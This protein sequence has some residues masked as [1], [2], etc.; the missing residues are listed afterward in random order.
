M[1]TFQIGIAV[2]V[3]LDL[4]VT[5]PVFGQAGSQRLGQAILEPILDSDLLVGQRIGHS[6]RVTG[7]HLRGQPGGQ[8][9][10]N[11]QSRQP[12]VTIPQSNPQAPAVQQFKPVGSSRPCH[13]LEHRSF[14]Q[15]HPEV[16]QQRRPLLVSSPLGL[17]LVEILP[18]FEGGFGATPDR[19]VNGHFDRGQHLQDLGLQR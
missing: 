7:D 11:L 4:Q 15:R 2:A 14:H 18:Q 12:I 6:H 8:Q 9:V 17:P 1:E 10:P 13:R 3:D 19:Q 5:Q 16:H